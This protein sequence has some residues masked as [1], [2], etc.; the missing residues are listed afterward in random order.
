MFSSCFMVVAR[1]E[2]ALANHG[3]ARGGVLGCRDER[4][5]SSGC[6]GPVGVEYMAVGGRNDALLHIY[7]GIDDLGQW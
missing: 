1:A 3:L 4:C 2:H 5:G 6:V 7:G